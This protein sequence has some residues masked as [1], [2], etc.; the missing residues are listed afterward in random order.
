MTRGEIHVIC[1]ELDPK[2]SGIVLLSYCHIWGTSAV[3]GTFRHMM[4]KDQ[5]KSNQKLIF[6][7]NAQKCVKMTKKEKPERVRRLLR[8]QL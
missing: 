8:N 6:Q 7:E 5:R 1:E 3:P 4:G 2:H